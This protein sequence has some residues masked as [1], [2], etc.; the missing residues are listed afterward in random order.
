MAPSRLGLHPP[1]RPRPSAP[2]GDSSRPGESPTTYDEPE[3]AKAVTPAVAGQGL[4]AKPGPDHA[5]AVADREAA[6]GNSEARHRVNPVGHCFMFCRRSTCRSCPA[7]R[8]S[9]PDWRGMISGPAVVVARIATVPGRTRR[10]H[11]AGRIAT[12]RYDC[13]LCAAGPALAGTRQSG[14]KG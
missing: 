7:L 5:F 3:R 13:E 14:G 11:R 2:T 4:G 12:F 6:R 1:F 8:G 10:M 9:Y